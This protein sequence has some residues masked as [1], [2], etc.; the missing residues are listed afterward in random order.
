MSGNLRKIACDAYRE[1]G[2]PSV[3]FIIGYAIS[4]N[5]FNI[6]IDFQILLLSWT[7]GSELLADMSVFY[8][9]EIFTVIVLVLWI[10]IRNLFVGSEPDP[11]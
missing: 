8:P 5:R 9:S 10:R 4:R 6:E 7:F 1:E 2:F 11:E 3:L